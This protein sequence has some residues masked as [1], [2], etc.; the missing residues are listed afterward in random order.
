MGLTPLYKEEIAD[1]EMLDETRECPIVA[2]TTSRLIVKRKGQ[3]IT[4][5]IPKPIVLVDTR[6]QL[7]FTFT[8]F[9]HRNTDL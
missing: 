6:E 1:I 8:R 5:K 4:R 2:P 3:S 7:P 9:T